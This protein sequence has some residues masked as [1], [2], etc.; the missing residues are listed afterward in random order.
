MLLVLTCGI[1]QGRTLTPGGSGDTLFPVPRGIRENVNFWRDVFSRYKTSEV[2]YHDE[3]RVDRVYEVSDLGK[4]WVSDHA[5]K[6]LIRRREKKIRKIL[7]ALAYG[8]TPPSGEG[9]LVA[10]IRKMFADQPRSEL[11]RAIS[12]IRSQPGLKE[13]FRESYV[14]SGRY[15]SHFRKV[16]RKYSLPTDLTLLPH[17]ES[18]FRKSISSHA[19]ASGMWQFT[20][21]TGRLF[22]RVDRTI[23]GRSDPY[24]SA[25][26][27][28]RLFKRNYE[29]LKAWPLAI[30]AY[31]HG[32]TGMRRAVRQLGSKDIG[33]IA[34]RYNSRTFGF[35]SR[36]FYASFIAAVHVHKN[37][38]I[39]FGNVRPDPPEKFAV[40]HLPGYIR[41]YQLT[42]RIG[43]DRKVLRAMNPALRPSVLRGGR[44]IPR[45]YP[46]RVPLDEVARVRRSYF[47]DSSKLAALKTD[48]NSKWVWVRSG[49]TLG[50]IARRFRVSLRSLK[51]E[52][53]LTGSMIVVGDR[54]RIP[55]KNGSRKSKAVASKS[56]PTQS[57]KRQKKAPK[58]V[59][60]A[61]A[62]MSPKPKKKVSAT[63]PAM[64]SKAPARI[65]SLAGPSLAP[66]D[67][68]LWMAEDLNAPPNLPERGSEMRREALRQ[69][70]A[71]RTSHEGK[72]GW[73][74]VQENETIGHY[75]RWLRI[76]PRVIRR[77]NKIRSN[78]R[79]RVG[80]KIRVPLRRV[81]KK[82]FLDK[83][84]SFHM[85][86]EKE[87]LRKYSVSRTDRHVLKRGEN[88]WTLVMQTYKVPLWLFKQYNAKKNLHQIS[89]GEELVF[90]RLERRSF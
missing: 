73:V 37:A 70:L 22:M 33:V 53:E 29:D 80:K 57:V 6:R 82:N 68:D 25:D 27:A 21:A 71:V 67:E 4:P 77:M 36:N 19:G 65:S 54:L 64:E 47:Q 31:N 41:I 34:R 24:I 40:F 58:P 51:K 59:Q 49:D 81:S 60:V 90:P 83:R 8:R 32:G 44:R 74:R 18:G 38:K 50:G 52:N 11:R 42:Q 85:D 30:T 63:T 20:R 89:I 75:S 35:A 88:V 62:E 28:A 5:Q 15:L 79:V 43:I 72:V 7:T 14:R 66:K 87:F 17:V 45:G 26:A 48:E 3:V 10:R 16:F 78:R 56:V 12:R 2:A 1:A 13:R 39:Y 69:V 86:I 23:D 61:K 55:Q 84:V 76:S 9:R 46:L